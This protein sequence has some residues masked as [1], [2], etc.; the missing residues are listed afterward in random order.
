MPGEHLGKLAAFGKQMEIFFTQNAL[1]YRKF[2]DSVMTKQVASNKS[3]L[4]LKITLQNTQTY[5]LN[6]NGNYVQKYL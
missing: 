6:Y 5:K 4:I 2:H 1:A 3:S